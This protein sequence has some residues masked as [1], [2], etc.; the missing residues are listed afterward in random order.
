[1]IRLKHPEN[2]PCKPCWELKYCPY[3]ILVEISPLIGEQPDIKKIKAL[4][5]KLKN[6]F[7]KGE[8]KGKY[9]FDKIDRLFYLTP[10][11]WEYVIEY[12][13]NE[14]TCKVF[15]HICPV[16]LFYEAATET[17]TYRSH[18]RNIPRDVMLKVVRRDNQICQICNKNVPDTEIEFDHVIPYSRGGPTTVENLRL[19]CRS[20][21][22]KKFT[23]LEEVLGNKSA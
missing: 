14:L 16:F 5:T 4:H 1:M 15:G 11:N 9:L 21:N 2:A 13:T 17:V 23:S 10:S 12:D 3:G 6:Q 7:L 19:V 18:S 22:R 20:C 8:I